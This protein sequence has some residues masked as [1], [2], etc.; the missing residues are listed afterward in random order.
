MKERILS[1]LLSFGM[2]G[3]LLAWQAGA[4]AAAESGE[5]VLVSEDFETYDVDTTPGQLG[6]NVLGNTTPPSVKEVSGSRKMELMAPNPGTGMMIPFASQAGVIR[7]RFEFQI[8][9]AWLKAPIT[10]TDST[11]Q[12]VS[13]INICNQTNPQVVRFQTASG[14]MLDAMEAAG[15]PIL[16]NDGDTRSVCFVLDIPNGTQ[17]FYVDDVLAFSDQ[18]LLSKAKDVAA[19]SIML[20]SM[21]GDLPMYIDDLEITAEQG[22]EIRFVAPEDTLDNILAQQAEQPLAFDSFERG[23]MERWHVTGGTLSTYALS[24][25]NKRLALRINNSHPSLRRMFEPLSGRF[26]LETTFC[27]DKAGMEGCIRLFD[28]TVG[29]AA[30]VLLNNINLDGGFFGADG[31]SRL[32]STH[33]EPNHDYLLTFVVDT[34]AN[35]YSLY[36]DGEPVVEQA[37]MA[38]VNRFIT[39]FGVEIY[40]VEGNLG[41]VYLDDFRITR[42]IDPAAAK[43]KAVLYRAYALF[44]ALSPLQYAQEKQ[45]LADAI[46]TAQKSLYQTGKLDAAGLWEAMDSYL[47]SQGTETDLPDFAQWSAAGA[48]TRSDRKGNQLTHYAADPYTADS[49][50]TCTGLAP[51]NY[52][53][54]AWVR[55]NGDAELAYIYANGYGGEELR[56]GIPR[57]SEWRQIRIR[58]ID[59]QNGQ[60]TVG[61][62][63]KGDAGDWVD[64]SDV[65]LV[66]DDIPYQFLKG[67]DPSYLTELEKN[68]IK[69]YDEAGNE[70]DYFDIM[71]EQGFNTVRILTE[72]NP[73]SGFRT[74]EETLALARRAK[75][76]GMGV[77]VDIVCSDGWANGG[78]QPLPAEWLALGDFDKILDAMYDYIYDLLD[79]L[80]AQGTPPLMVQI[81]NEIDGGMMYSTGVVDDKPA[82]VYSYGKI[83]THPVQLIQI[84]NNGSKAVRKVSADNG[85]DIKVIVHLDSA[86]DLYRCTSFLDVIHGRTEA[87][88]GL[89]V[90][91]DILG[92]S[93]YTVWGSTIEQLSMTLNA[94]YDSYGKPMILVENAYPWHRKSTFYGRTIPGYPATVQGQKRFLNDTMLAVKDVKDGAAFGV[95]EWAV[96]A[97][98]DQY[99]WHNG[100]LFDWDTHVVLDSAK[101]FLQ[102]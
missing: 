45:R 63:T 30:C 80:V 58:G 69:Y 31:K 19:L 32:L 36:I 78:Q 77:A 60:C 88:R 23:E 46:V 1:L 10:I 9:N 14:Q 5:T 70:R 61:L 72:V 17:D 94:L 52:Q 33:F 41:N 57:A 42:E 49:K 8:A 44:D 20:E 18:P 39:G 15:L 4:P 84:L 96:E 48:V 87:T 98:P 12:V 83:D 26:M 102:N 92:L 37:A 95:W 86:A 65:Q 24:Q 59:V 100:T 62:F 7:I 67:F 55:S 93:Y 50:F 13:A 21:W 38:S 74:T 79:A 97:V 35:Q 16:N 64:I 75:E 22:D 101:A 89:S 2:L 27:T 73:P 54:T 76:H 25:V 81:G 82:P 66:K 51:G 6:W 53:L 29:T 11:G 40:G 56:T 85:V 71:A 91:Y 3:S 43:D 34:D 90:D 68:G 28:G 99:S 47:F